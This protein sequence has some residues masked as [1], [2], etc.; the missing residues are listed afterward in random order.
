MTLGIMTLGMIIHSIGVPVGMI[1]GTTL[2]M[3]MVIMARTGMAIGA[4]VETG[5][6]DIHGITQ[7]HTDLYGT[8]YLRMEIPIRQEVCTK[9]TQ[10]VTIPPQDTATVERMATL[11]ATHPI[12]TGAIITTPIE[13]LTAPT[14]AL[15]AQE[16]LRQTTITL[17]AEHTARHKTTAVMAAVPVSA[18]VQEV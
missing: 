10:R 5:D 18:A 4:V 6:G 9:G 17:F 15:T 11:T 16:A 2:A 1:L 14:E 3:I 12:A 8:E 7:Y 13:A